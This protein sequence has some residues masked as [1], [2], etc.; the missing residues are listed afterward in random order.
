[1][2]MQYFGKTLTTRK[3][4]VT[5]GITGKSIMSINPNRYMQR[6]PDSGFTSRGKPL[7]PIKVKAYIESSEAK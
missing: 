6:W 3:L 5:T 7:Q 2:S 1:M 4:L